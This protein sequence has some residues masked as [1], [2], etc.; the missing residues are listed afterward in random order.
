MNAF[1]INS[2][3]EAEFIATAAAKEALWLKMLLS[4]ITGQ[5]KTVVVV[6][7]NQGALKFIHHYHV[8]QRTTH[9]DIAHRLVQYRVKRGELVCSFAASS[10]MVSDCLTN[11]VSMSQFINNVKAMGLKI[12]AFEK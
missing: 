7:D 11:A 8:H 4:E 5:T 3:S 9:I 10:T 12:R 6:V 2:N 1:T